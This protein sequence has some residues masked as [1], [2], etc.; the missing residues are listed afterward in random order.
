ME[1]IREDKFIYQ[2]G[3]IDVVVPQCKKCGNSYIE[4]G[5]KCEIK[6]IDMDIRLNKIKCEDFKEKE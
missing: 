4:T 6:T 1:E 2:E 5:L 3:D